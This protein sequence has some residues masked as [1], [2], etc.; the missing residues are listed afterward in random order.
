M[1]ACGQ[2]A[3]ES[4]KG[5]GVRRWRSAY[6]GLVQAGAGDPVHCHTGP[7][8]MTENREKGMDSVKHIIFMRRIVRQGTEGCSHETIEC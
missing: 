2:Y 4:L 5:A 8:G 1:P 3:A 7:P 6:P